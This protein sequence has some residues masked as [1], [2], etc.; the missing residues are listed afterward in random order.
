[1][2]D[3]YNLPFYCMIAAAFVFLG[4]QLAG[5]DHSG[6]HGV[7]HSLDHGVDH[8]LDHDLDCEAEFDGSFSLLGFINRGRVP[9]S[10]L[11][12]SGLFYWG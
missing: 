8:G 11:L 1:M 4:L 2:L 7:D 12:M 3:G 5:G 9:L 10:L 6:D